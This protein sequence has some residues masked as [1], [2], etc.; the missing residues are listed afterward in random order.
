MCALPTCV[1]GYWI[2]HPQT[3][4]GWEQ[5]IKAETGV[6][7]KIDFIATPS[8]FV[9]VLHGVQF[10][11]PEY[12]NLLETAAIEVRMGEQVQIK[13]PHQV[14]R[15]NNRGL[16]KLIKTIHQNPIRRGVKKEWR[17]SF[18]EPIEISHVEASELFNAQQPEQQSV[19]VNALLDLDRKTFVLDQLRIDI[20][21]SFDGT[22][23]AANFSIPQKNDLAAANSPPEKVE[24]QLK[25][26][27]RG[28]AIWLHTFD[29]PLPCWLASEF[30]EDIAT[31]LGNAATF[32]GELKMM[33]LVGRSQE[34]FLNGR[35]EGLNSP[36]FGFNVAN[37]SADMNHC[38]FVDGTFK[39]WSATLNIPHDGQYRH[40]KIDPANL[41]SPSQRVV[42]G[43]AIR[44]AIANGFSLRMANEP[45]SSDVNQY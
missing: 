9:T 28:H 15:V 26:E 40:F 32:A 27:M 33:A 6:E 17:I 43:N 18:D 44:S 13:V 36:A 38:H 7:A 8:P 1:C 45:G 19:D 5:A 41:Y 35:F 14:T 39:N 2:C 34:V 3:A 24:L 11:D 10:E 23:V 31:G 12:G 4:A 16:A 25:K 29:Q 22:L 30:T 21:P 37:L 20:E 42:V